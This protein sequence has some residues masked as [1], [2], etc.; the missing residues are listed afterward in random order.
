MTKLKAINVKELL[1]TFNAS[2]SIFNEIKES[3]PIIIQQQPSIN[4]E[5]LKDLNVIISNLKNSMF[6]IHNAFKYNDSSLEELTDKELLFFSKKTNISLE[7]IEEFL[8]FNEILQ[9]YDLE[10]DFYTQKTLIIEKIAKVEQEKA[11]KALQEEKQRQ[12]ILEKKLKEE[13]LKKQNQEKIITENIFS[14]IDLICDIPNTNNSNE[15]LI[16][17]DNTNNIDLEDFD[18]NKS[19]NI[20]I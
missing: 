15:N 7:N 3:L 18:D 13:T 10:K 4:F 17:K 1:S 9:K 6:Q 20:E 5:E 11:Q 19:F 8:E 14:A 2:K 12:L 16:S